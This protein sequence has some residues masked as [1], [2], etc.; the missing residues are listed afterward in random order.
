[1]AWA[2]DRELESAVGYEIARKR[3]RKESADGLWRL[4]SLTVSEEF[5]EEV[6]W[7]K[8]RTAGGGEAARGAEAS[9]EDTGGEAAGGEAAGGDSASGDGVGG[10]DEASAGAAS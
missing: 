4:I 2:A 1:M 3:W 7:K 6:W 5:V 10:D 9:G 8:R